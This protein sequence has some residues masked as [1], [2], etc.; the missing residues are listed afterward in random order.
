MDDEEF[1]LIGK[2]LGEIVRLQPTLEPSFGIDREEEKEVIYQPTI[3]LVELTL[4][5]KLENIFCHPKDGEINEYT[6]ANKFDAAITKEYKDAVKALTRAH[7]LIRLA[8]KFGCEPY[9]FDSDSLDHINE[10]LE[11]GNMDSSSTITDK[12]TL[13][14]YIN[15]LSE[16][17]KKK[18]LRLLKR[19]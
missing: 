7:K 12:E 1:L 16:G 2:G 8:R 19:Y 5:Q 4:E 15:T 18:V 13:L 10:C 17:R 6:V 14:D 3:P 9:K 11:R